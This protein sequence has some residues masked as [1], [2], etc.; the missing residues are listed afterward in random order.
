MMDTI[1][2]VRPGILIGLLGIIFGIGWAFWLILGH[3]SIHSSLEASRAALHQPGQEASHNAENHIKSVKHVHSDG[4]E[5][6]I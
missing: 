4:N 6:C 5:H 1:R 3:E 2:P